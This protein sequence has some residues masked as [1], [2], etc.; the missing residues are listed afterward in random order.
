MA[1]RVSIG[2]YD[3]EIAAYFAIFFI[4]MCFWDLYQ[5]LK[6][7]VINMLVFEP[8][9]GYT[10]AGFTDLSSILLTGLYVGI[11]S[12]VSLAILKSRILEI[13]AAGTGI[14]LKNWV[15]ITLLNVPIM[16][17]VFLISYFVLTPVMGLTV[18]ATSLAGATVAAI[19]LSVYSGFFTIFAF[20]VASVFRT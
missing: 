17:I 6:S 5:Y 4:S 19:D 20:Y 10:P 2:L 12:L 9:L 16:I 18:T 14:P 8:A 11:A 1:E 7:L 13:L 3:L 15:S